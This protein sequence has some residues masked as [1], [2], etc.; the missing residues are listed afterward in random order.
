MQNRLPVY[1]HLAAG[2]AG[3][4]SLDGV[5]ANGGLSVASKMASVATGQE[6]KTA[7]SGVTTGATTGATGVDCSDFGVAGAFTVSV[8]FGSSTGASTATVTGISFNGTANGVSTLAGAASA[9]VLILGDSTGVGT[10]AGSDTGAGAGFGTEAGAG[11]DTGAALGASGAGVATW[12]VI[13]TG[14]GAA[15]GNA[16]LATSIGSLTTSLAISP[17]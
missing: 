2:T 8:F 1:S 3:A 7:F 12:A 13:A 14:A 10:G 4:S 16:S 5:L 11:S 6:G 9:G 17:A 15:T